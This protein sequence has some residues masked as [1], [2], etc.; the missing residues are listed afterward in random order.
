[1]ETI[2]IAMLP[3]FDKEDI[4][5]V[6]VSKIPH[7]LGRSEGERFVKWL[8]FCNKGLMLLDETNE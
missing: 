2:D 4:I 1:M 3:T 8:E 5:K 7:F 6:D